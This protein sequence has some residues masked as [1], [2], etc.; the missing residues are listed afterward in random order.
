MAQSKKYDY[1]V[2]Q[3]DTGWNT[4]ILR[5]ASSKKTVVSKCQGGFVTEADAHAWGQ[6]EIK[7]FLHNININRQ[8]KRLRKQHDSGQEVTHSNA[9]EI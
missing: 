3:D 6:N 5:R 9:E 8:K 7:L 1:L 2:K 4:E